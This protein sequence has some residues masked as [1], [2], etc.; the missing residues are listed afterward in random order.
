VLG[1]NGGER[2][3]LMKN[4]LSMKGEL[5]EIEVDGLVF[6]IYHGTDEQLKMNLVN[7]GKY[8][9]IVIGHIE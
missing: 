6:G 2:V 4:F 3:H 8:D 1:N 5:G 9:I 7:C